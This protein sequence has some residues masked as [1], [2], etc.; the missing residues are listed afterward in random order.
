MLDKSYI[1]KP[2]NK[3]C[4]KCS[5]EEYDK[6]LI[7]LNCPKCGSKFETIYERIEISI[8]KIIGD[9]D[10]QMEFL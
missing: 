9:E 6:P 8:S 10:L 7:V 1:L 3:R 2:L 4:T 5:F